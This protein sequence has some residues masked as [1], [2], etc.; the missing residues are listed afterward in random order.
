[1]T[2]LVIATSYIPAI[3]MPPPLAGSIYW[4]D[5]VIFIA[6]YL[7]D[8]LAAFVVGGLGT[9]LFD[10]IKGN[11]IMMGFSLLIHGLQ[12]VATSVLLHFVFGKLKKREPLWAGIASVVGALVVIIGYF[13]FYWLIAPLVLND[14]REYGLLY[15]AIRIPRNIIQEIIGI[16]IAMIICYATT[17]KKQLEKNHLLP[18]FRGEILDKNEKVDIPKENN[19]EIKQPE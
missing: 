18:D 1:M 17:F 13:L 19:E 7:F 9:F 6:A 5:F 10:L 15:A 8:P 3:P 12:A 14:G 2:A 4:C 16:S 11:A